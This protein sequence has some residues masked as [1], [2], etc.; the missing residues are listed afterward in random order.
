MVQNLL[1]KSNQHV[2]DYGV[3]MLALEGRIVLTDEKDVEDFYGV[4]AS[5]LTKV[6][7][8]IAQLIRTLEKKFDNV[9]E[10]YLEAMVL[11]MSKPELIYLTE[12]VTQIA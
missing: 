1:V 8:M 6:D 5:E 9:K 7:F 3:L 12:L 10:N 2:V 4:P 11:D